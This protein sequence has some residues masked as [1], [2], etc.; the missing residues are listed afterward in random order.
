MTPF[1]VFH[2]WTPCISSEDIVGILSDFKLAIIA[3]PGYLF[4]KIWTCML[5][6]NVGFQTVLF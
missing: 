2:F 6:F 1:K 5:H 3:L 4:P